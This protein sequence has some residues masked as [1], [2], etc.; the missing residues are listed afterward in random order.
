[1]FEHGFTTAQDGS[2]YGLSVVRTIGNAHGWDV[3]VA[4]AADG[5]ARFEITGIDFLY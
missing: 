3:S 4:D 5:G 1:V 2:G